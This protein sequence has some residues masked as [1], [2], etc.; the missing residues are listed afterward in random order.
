MAGVQLRAMHLLAL[1]YL[2]GV[3][4]SRWDWHEHLIG[5]GDHLKLTRL[6]R[7]N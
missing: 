1:A 7:R 4:G 2:M 5:D 3:A 6:D